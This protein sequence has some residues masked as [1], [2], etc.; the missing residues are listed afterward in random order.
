EA[1]GSGLRGSTILPAAPF[2]RD[3]SVAE[4]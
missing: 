4:T 2:N 1:A 3:T